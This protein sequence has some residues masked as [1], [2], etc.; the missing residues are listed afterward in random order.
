MIEDIR[1]EQ[2]HT[3]VE[4]G[5]ISVIMSEV[6]KSVDKAVVSSD[7]HNRRSDIIEKNLN[8]FKNEQELKNQDIERQLGVVAKAFKWVGGIITAIIVFL[9]TGFL[10][11]WFGW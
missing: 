1:K 10:K 9:T 3:A 4:L 5:K 7:S 11:F 6:K 2:N 8:D